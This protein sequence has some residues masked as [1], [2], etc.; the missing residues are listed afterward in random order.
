MLSNFQKQKIKSAIRLA[1]ILN[2]KSS[3]K[4]GDHWSLS[5]SGEVVKNNKK[6]KSYQ[7]KHRTLKV[8]TFIFDVT[9][10]NKHWNQS[11]IEVR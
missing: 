7:I 9:N 5:E 3:L 11:R 10:E 2:F 6:L 1:E 8:K 4:M